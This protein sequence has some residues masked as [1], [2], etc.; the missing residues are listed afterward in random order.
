MGESLK[1]AEFFRSWMCCRSANLIY[2]VT[3]LFILRESP[4]IP[5]VWTG[6]LLLK[7]RY[8]KSGCCL[9]QDNDLKLRSKECSN[10]GDVII[11]D[12][13]PKRV[14]KHCA[15]AVSVRL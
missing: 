13:V 4:L 7:M 14:T 9:E 1:T 5:S 11:N 10:G 12:K 15:V 6:T 3:G 8:S 2:F